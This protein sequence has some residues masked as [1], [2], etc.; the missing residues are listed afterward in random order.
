MS[1]VSIPTPLEAIE[2]Q[3]DNDPRLT[4]DARTLAKAVVRGL[5]EPC[6]H[7]PG[8]PAFSALTIVSLRTAL[9]SEAELEAIA[10]DA[11]A[12]TEA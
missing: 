5:A 7:V 3:L 9:L 2:A 8:Y 1:D 12:A 4:V 10:A 11:F 6:G